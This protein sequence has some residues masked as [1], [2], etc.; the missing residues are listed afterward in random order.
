MT[1]LLMFLS[2]LSFSLG[3]NKTKTLCKIFII[4]YSPIYPSSSCSSKIWSYDAPPCRQSRTLKKKKTVGII[5]SPRVYI[6]PPIYPLPILPLISLLPTLS[7]P[8]LSTTNQYKVQIAVDIRL[9][10]HGA[11][12]PSSLVLEQTGLGRGRGGGG[13]GRGARVLVCVLDLGE[14]VLG[15]LRGGVVWER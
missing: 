7:A 12:A 10:K 8:L 6:S 14:L 9:S 11:I 3:C 15:R 1:F 4:F 13:L 5:I 2:S